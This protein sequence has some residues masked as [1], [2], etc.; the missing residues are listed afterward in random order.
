[1]IRDAYLICKFHEKAAEKMIPTDNFYDYFVQLIKHTNELFSK[2]NI[3]EGDSI[4][5]TNMAF[6]ARY[7]EKYKGK[8]VL[9]LIFAMF[10]DLSQW[11]EKNLKDFKYG[12]WV[13][14]RQ[15]LTSV[16]MQVFNILEAKDFIFMGDDKI[17]HDGKVFL[18]QIKDIEEVNK[19]WESLLSIIPEKSPEK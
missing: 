3:R 14:M 6:S 12:I 4:Y 2:Y 10:A 17:M 8:K 16:T 15:S 19:Y 11:W 1:M 5:G 18:V 7:L 13:Q 9:S